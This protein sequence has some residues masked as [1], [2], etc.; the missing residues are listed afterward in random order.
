MGT[1]N[2][3]IGQVAEVN[4][5]ILTL[6]GR[7]TPNDLL[8]KRDQLVDQLNVIVGVTA[9]DRPNRTVQLAVT[10]SGVLLVDGD[11]TATADHRVQPGRRYAWTCPRAVCA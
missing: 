10:G 1:A 3:L 9:T 5:Q 2:G 7:P 8:D 6:G 4:R 11:R